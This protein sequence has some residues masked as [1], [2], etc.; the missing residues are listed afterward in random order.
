[1]PPSAPTVSSLQ[2]ELDVARGLALAAGQLV[3]GYYG[4]NV[5]VERKEGDEPVTR[6]DREAS[7]LILEGL[8]AAFP[9]DVLISEEGADDLR[10]LEA[11]RR[12]WFIDPIDG[13]RDF[14]RGASGFSVMIGLAIAGRPRL[15]IVYQPVGERLFVAGPGV[16]ATMDDP[17]GRRALRCS[18]VRDLGQL[19]LVASKSHRTPKIDE[20]KNALGIADELNIG[21]V[22]LKLGL[23]ALAERDLYVNPSSKSKAWDTCA[24]EA[25][26]CEA[27]GRITDLYGAP[28]SYD[29]PQLSNQRGLVAS[30]GVAHEDVIA[31]LRPL[32]PPP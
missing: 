23:I 16:G 31:R 19:R 27:G 22:G 2:H 29:A 9:G 25:I 8:G 10:R 28:L 12:V 32:F 6:A 18:P 30:N 1:M 3:L 14:I 11:G 7:A 21:S 24:P 15:G 26:L 5:A 4:T 13:T 20:V 17:G